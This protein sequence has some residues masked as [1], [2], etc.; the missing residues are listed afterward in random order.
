MQFHIGTSGWVYPH[1]RERF[2]PAELPEPEWLSF[3]A[4]QLQSVEIN[5]SFYRL[6]TREN[7]LCWHDATP[8]G[9][10]FAVKASRYITHMRNLLQPRETLPPLLDAVAALGDKL[11][12]LLFQLPPRWNA[13][14]ERLEAFL[15][16]LP[17]GLQ[18]VFEL[19]NQSWHSEEILALLAD[20]NAAF[21]IYDLGGITS[22]RE[23]TADFLYLR[24]HGP[25][26]TY[27]GYYDVATLR[28]WARWLREQR[29]DR[30]YI[31]F[32]NDESAYAVRNAL[33]L[34]R[35]LNRPD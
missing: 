14:R 35:L 15:R 25:V 12:P 10:V 31:Y 26:D 4:G 29:V 7:F 8:D 1:W 2:Y 11:G 18:V 34:R 17:R 16:V 3:Y 33:E 20:F 22:P 32:D 24:L 23:I 19:R 6:P 9:F 21:C 27:R 28:R 30:A 13:N 5:R